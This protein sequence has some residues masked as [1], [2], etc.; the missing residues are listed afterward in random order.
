MPF[1]RYA[2]PWLC[3]AFAMLRGDRHNKAKGDHPLACLVPLSCHLSSCATSGLEVLPAA[4][5]YSRTR[6]LGAP[7]CVADMVLQAACLGARDSLTP[8]GVVVVSGVVNAFGDWLTVCRLKMGVLGAAAAT[9]TAEVV[10]MSLLGRAVLKAQG[11][12]AL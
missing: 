5:L 12:P 3:H 2:T 11:E 1:L 8:L 4:V 6:I 9:A 10:S 7:A